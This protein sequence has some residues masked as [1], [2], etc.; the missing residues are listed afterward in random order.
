VFKAV[1]E[2]LSH[3]KKDRQIL[4]LGMNPKRPEPCLGKVLVQY[5]LKP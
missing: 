1:K 4:E 2:Y 3:I 5:F